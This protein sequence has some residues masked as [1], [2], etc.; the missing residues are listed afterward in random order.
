MLGANNSFNYLSVCLVLAT[1]LTD[2]NK[3][4]VVLKLTK[5]AFCWGKKDTEQIKKTP[6]DNSKAMR[7][8]RQSN[9]CGGGYSWVDSYRRQDMGEPF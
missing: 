1:G 7:T 6:T 3:P 2:V 5:L 8:V 9:V 4:H